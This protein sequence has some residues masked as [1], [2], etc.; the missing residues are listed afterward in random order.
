MMGGLF[1][2]INVRQ[3]KYLNNI[4]EQNHR[5]I[6][7]IT[8]QIKGFK[9]FHSADATFSGIEFHH[10]LKK[11]QYTQLDNQTIFEEFYGR[12]A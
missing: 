12:A 2:Q 10:M 1:L 11:G 8:K 4:V 6:K 5:F 7:K 3:V 9:E